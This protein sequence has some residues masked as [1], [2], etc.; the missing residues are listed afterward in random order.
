M[1]ELNVEIRLSENNSH[2]IDADIA[3]VIRNET[4]DEDIEN[5]ETVLKKL[6]LELCSSIFEQQE[7][8]SN[9]TESLVIVKK[10]HN[11]ALVNAKL[12]E[13]NCLR[14]K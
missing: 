13:N 14:S 10:W 3:A 9:I 7:R 1:E 8:V 12:R 6:R 11:K 5:E 4:N 2:I